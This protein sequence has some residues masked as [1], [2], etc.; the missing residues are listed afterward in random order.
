MELY[1]QFGHGMK[2]M[3]IDLSKEWNGTSVILSPRDITPKQLEQWMPDFKKAKISCLFDPQC[4]FPKCN[5]K[6]LVQYGYWCSDL[7]TNLSS[8]DDYET[9]LIK[10]IDYY[11]N[12]IEADKFIIPGIMRPFSSDWFDKWI[13]DCNKLINVARKVVKNRKLLLTLTLPCDL[14]TGTEDNIEKIIEIT[15]KWDVD[16]YYIIAEPCNDKYLVDNP[17]WISNLLQICAGMKLQEKEVIVGYG[18]QQL[19]CLTT[20]KVDAI[21]SGTYLNVRRFS[22]KFESIENIKRKSV[23]YYYPHSL[24]E[25]KI[26]YLDFAF[27]SGIIDEMKPN[28]DMNN[29]YISLIF[30][31]ILPSSTAFNETLAFKHYLQ[32]LKK[33]VELCSRKTYKQTVTANEMLLNTAERRIEFLEKNGIYAQTR[34]FKDIVDINRSA[35]QRLSNTRQFLLEHSW[36]E[37]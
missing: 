4:Y 13:R 2:S 26:S 35:I 18:N 17:V 20:A 36:N 5:H 3:S 23:W 33:Q 15:N 1:L 12:I 19:I 9:T 27:N 28:T 8:Q 11:N 29:K 37:L 30:S 31:G 25:Y 16:G 14:L 21:A 24:S 22:N 32:S 6:N 34:N 7:N 10:K